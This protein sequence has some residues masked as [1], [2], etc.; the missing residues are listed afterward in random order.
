MKES[1]GEFVKYK[2]N[3]S[4]EIWSALVWDQESAFHQ[5]FLILMQVSLWIHWMESCVFGFLLKNDGV[6]F[7]SLIVLCFCP[8][9]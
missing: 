1:I 2:F 3:R 7:H 8:F 5:M 9:S 6:F 4:S